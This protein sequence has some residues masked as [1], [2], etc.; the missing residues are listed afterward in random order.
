MFPFPSS[1][2]LAY[3][4]ACLL[5]LVLY[6]LFL[7]GSV[8]QRTLFETKEDSSGAMTTESKQKNRLMPMGPGMWRLCGMFLFL[9]TQIILPANRIFSEDV[10]TVQVKNV[11]VSLW[12]P[13]FCVLVFCYLVLLVVAVCQVIRQVIQSWN[14]TVLGCWANIFVIGLIACGGLAHLY[15]DHWL[16]NTRISLALFKQS[17]KMP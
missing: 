13:L 17:S 12:F 9:A 11:T 16:E 3:A 2:S 7:Y 14:V 15:L 10:V 4:F 1:S 6:F 5:W 8:Y